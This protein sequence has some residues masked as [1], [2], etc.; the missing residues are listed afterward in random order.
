[1]PAAPKLSGVGT[2]PRPNKCIQTRL[3]KTRAVSG[4]SLEASQWASSSRPLVVGAI[5]PREGHTWFYKMM[6]DEQIAGQ[7]QAAFLKF[8]QTV[9]YPNAG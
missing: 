9:R 8:I 3:T 6:G 5:V 1:M 4:F 2:N 7:Q